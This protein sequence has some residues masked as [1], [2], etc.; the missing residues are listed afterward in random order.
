MRTEVRTQG[1]ESRQDTG[2]RQGAD[3]AGVTGVTEFAEIASESELRE[4]VGEPN[5]RALHEVRDRLHDLDRQWLTRSPLR[6]VA[7]SDAEGRCD[8]SPKG[9]PGGFTLVLDDTTTAVP[10]RPGNR[11]VDGFRTILTNPR[12][13]SITSSRAAT[14]PHAS[15]AAPGSCATPRSST[16]R[17]GRQGR[18]HAAGAA[19]RDRRGLLPLLQGLP[20]LRAVAAGEPAA[21]RG[22]FTGPP[23]QGRRGPRT[24]L[25]QLEAHYGPGYAERLYD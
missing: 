19:R 8:V 17:H 5:D 16:R 25:E 7:A 22:A 21:R 23:S 20:A 2:I 18:P 9:D 15:T 10:D 6:H 13:G 4:L 1:A 3:F 24:P 11:R 12:S 14:T